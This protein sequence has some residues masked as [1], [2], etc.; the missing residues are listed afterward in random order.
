MKSWTLLYPIVQKIPKGKVATYSQLAKMLST[1]PRVVGNLL[2]QNPD[3][4]NIPCH[5][6]VNKQG[7]VSK[8]YAFG[9]AKEQTRRL[10]GERVK[11][12]KNGKVDLA[13]GLWDGLY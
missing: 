12:I 8:N 7:L 11:F 2:H 13:R 6:V 4:K 3:P 5:R 10:K 1:N 9:G